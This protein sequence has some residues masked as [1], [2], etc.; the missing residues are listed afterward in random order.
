MNSENNNDLNAISLGSV[1]NSNNFNT[2]P[3]EPV[4]PVAPIE[5]ADIPTPIS[6]NPNDVASINSTPVMPEVPI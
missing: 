4:A 2:N 3:I 5:N 6:P 1:D